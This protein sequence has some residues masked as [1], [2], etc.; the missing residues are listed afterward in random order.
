M[1]PLKT[2]FLLSGFMLAVIVGG[3]AHAVPINLNDFSASDV[4]AIS[5]NGTF[6]Q[7]NEDPQGGPSLLENNPGVGDLALFSAGP[8]AQISFRYTFSPEPSNNDRLRAS[9]IDPTNDPT[10]RTLFSGLDE[11]FPNA[12]TPLLTTVEFE[13]DLGALPSQIVGLRFELVTFN[14]PSQV[15]NFLDVATIQDV[16]FTPPSNVP[17]PNSLILSA[18]GIAS[19]LVAS[20]R[21][22]WRPAAS[23]TA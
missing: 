12:A 2:K 8:G 23:L 20:R 11:F 4:V 9:V 5:P 14:L 6:A 1:I 3:T 15:E 18:L 22:A 10:N 17:E 21:R 13:F 19:A 16:D 7:L